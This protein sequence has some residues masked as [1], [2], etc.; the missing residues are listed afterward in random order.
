MILLKRIRKAIA[1]KPDDAT[2]ISGNEAKE[3]THMSKGPR[4]AGVGR[5]AKTFKA[6]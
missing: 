6:I 4:A 1:L 3:K 5:D 2:T